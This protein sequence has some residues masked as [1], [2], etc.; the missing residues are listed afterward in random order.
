MKRLFGAMGLCVLAVAAQA[1]E[2][3]REISWER[4]KQAGEL[5][6]GEVH[7]ADDSAAFEYLESGAPSR[8]QAASS[9]RRA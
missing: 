5:L 9:R 6:A 1:N 4:Q 2:V 3:L 7:P 8:R